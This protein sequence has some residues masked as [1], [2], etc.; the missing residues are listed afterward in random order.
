MVRRHALLWRQVAEHVGRLLVVSA[1]EVAPFRSVGSIVGRR[2][3][4]VDPIAQSFLAA[5]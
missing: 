1:H 3:R 2:D 5:C 4:S